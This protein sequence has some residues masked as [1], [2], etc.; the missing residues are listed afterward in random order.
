MADSRE[1][2]KFKMILILLLMAFPFYGQQ[3]DDNK[4]AIRAIIDAYSESVITKDSIA[5]YSLF[6]EGNVVWCAAYKD[7]TQAREIEAKG[8]K[9]AGSNYF[10]G[11]YKGF[12]RGL[13]GD[14]STEDKFDTIK[15]V[16]DGTVASVTMDYSFWADHKMT[17][18]GSK[19]LNL[20]KRDGKWKITSVIYSLELIKY[21]KQPELKERQSR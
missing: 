21:F 17:N 10:S 18:W 6:N 1:I 20:I 2:R 7:R 19:Y 4:K 13:Y 9:K 14:K 5:F 3:K 15:I 8:E 12:M 11:S 16:E